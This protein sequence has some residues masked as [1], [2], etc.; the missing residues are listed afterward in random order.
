MV[1]LF[2]PAC[3]SDWEQVSEITSEPDFSNAIKHRAKNVV[4]VDGPAPA[5]V[6]ERSHAIKLQAANVIAG[7]P[8]PLHPSQQRATMQCSGQG[9]LVCAALEHSVLIVNSAHH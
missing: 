8:A 4:A 7:R 5:P 9:L 2:S 6:I 1:Y 3:A